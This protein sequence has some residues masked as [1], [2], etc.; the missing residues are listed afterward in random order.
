[1]QRGAAGE[2]YRPCS[3]IPGNG[4][5]GVM[6]SCALR[7]RM[8][9]LCAFAQQGSFFRAVTA[10]SSSSSSQQQQK[11]QQQKLQQQQS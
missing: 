2:R 11:L 9:G 8:N 6:G 1:M 5:G 7:V 3:G 10:A 4:G